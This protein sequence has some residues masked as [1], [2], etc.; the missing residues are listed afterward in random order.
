MTIH[1]G[2]IFCRANV[3][4]SRNRDFDR[5]AMALL[6]AREHG[7]CASQREESSARRVP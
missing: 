5:A 1:F 4:A 7:H 3:S 2:K 6:A